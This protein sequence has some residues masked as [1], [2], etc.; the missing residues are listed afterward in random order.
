M[1]RLAGFVLSSKDEEHK[2]AV[3]F[4]HLVHETIGMLRDPKFTAELIEQNIKRVMP[5]LLSEGPVSQRPIDDL[6]KRETDKHSDLLPIYV[7]ELLRK[8]EELQELRNSVYDNL[9]A[10]LGV[11]L[12]A[13]MCSTEP[14]INRRS[15]KFSGI[16]VRYYS[17]SNVFYMVRV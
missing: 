10:A 8:K 14:K 3:E 5:S 11:D 7:W 4:K 1:E 13:M 16:A 17:D 15:Q 2:D 12:H 9:G 6:L